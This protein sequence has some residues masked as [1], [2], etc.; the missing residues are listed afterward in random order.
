MSERLVSKPSWKIRRRLVFATLGFCAFVILY[1]TF[2]GKDTELHTT[3]ALGVIGAAVSTLGSY[4]FGV[5]WDDRNVLSVIAP[6]KP[7]MA[8]FAYR[9]NERRPVEPEGDQML[10]RLE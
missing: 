8:R 5:A 7:E 2:F 9:R 1:L 4:I 6:E 10:D 3:I